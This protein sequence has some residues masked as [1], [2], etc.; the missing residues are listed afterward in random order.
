MVPVGIYDE[1][2]VN[3]CEGNT[4]TVDCPS[5]DVPSERQNIAWRAA[6]RYLNAAGISRGLNISIQKGIPVGAGMGGGSADAAAVLLALDSLFGSPLPGNILHKIA[7]N[8]G[9]DVPFFLQQRPALATGIGENLLPVDSVPSY[10]LLLIKPPFNV[11]TAKVYGSLQLT[12]NEARIKLRTFLAM[13]W[14]LRE[15]LENDLESVT[16]KAHPQVGD[17]KRWLLSNGAVAALMTGSG[18]TVFGIF[19]TR[20][21]V[22]KVADLAERVWVG[23]WVAAAEVLGQPCQAKRPI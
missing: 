17:I 10:P 16:I 9:A 11:S 4:V 5:P 2:T 19:P 3:A 13:P 12:K 22:A 18:P 6:N 7:V 15:I 14:V 1:L 23:C 8:L 20:E 21:D